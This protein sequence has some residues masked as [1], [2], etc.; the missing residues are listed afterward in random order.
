MKLASFRYAGNESYGVVIDGD[1][2]DI[3]QA[4]RPQYPSLRAVIAADKLFEIESIAAKGSP[5]IHAADVIFIPV[6]DES[7][8]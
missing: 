5:R 3:G 7:K 6:I 1:I 4:L 8:G 2:V